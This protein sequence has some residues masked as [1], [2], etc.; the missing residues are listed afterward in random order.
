MKRNAALPSAI[1]IVFSGFSCAQTTSATFDIAS[2]HPSRPGSSGSTYS[3]TADRGV[4]VTNGTVKGL[5]E[6]AYD[7]RDFQI[8]GGP[9]WTD[10][11]FFDVVAKTLPAASDS[12][13]AGPANSIVETRLRLQALL[14]ERFQ[15]QLRRESRDLPEYILAVGKNGAKMKPS[16]AASAAGINAACGQMT[17]TNTTMANLAYKLSRTLD[18]PV[19]DQTNLS[20]NY[21]FVLN[22]TPD[23]GPCSPSTSASSAPAATISGDGPSLFTALQD[24]LGLQLKSVKGPVETLV[25][26]HVEPPSAN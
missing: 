26:D 7:V 17:G 25:I 5:I 9:G 10:S 23:T 14:L 15:L 24:Q 11:Q 19:V 12:A 3:F 13:A 4:K 1:L 22:W 8:L 21:N 6:M 20:G 16:Q 18:R 2:I